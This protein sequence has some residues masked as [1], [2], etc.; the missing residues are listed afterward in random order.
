MAK[1]WLTFGLQAGL[2]C[3]GAGSE[4]VA[5]LIAGHGYV[6]VPGVDLTSARSSLEISPSLAFSGSS[7]ML[8]MTIMAARV[9]IYEVSR[10]AH[11]A[12]G[13]LTTKSQLDQTLIPMR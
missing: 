4:Q 9:M 13:K 6:P 11:E 10:C 12:F 7:G 1:T 8:S 5:E 3:P 2:P